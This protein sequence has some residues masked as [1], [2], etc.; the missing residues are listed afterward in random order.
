MK[1]IILKDGEEVG[2]G[3]WCESCNR[4]HGVYYLC[5]YYPKD[6]RDQIKKK[7]DQFKEN[8]KNKEWCKKQIDSGIPSE[9]IEIFKM[10]AGV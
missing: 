10:F 5:E 2:H 9:G 3:R 7:S 4:E 8:L 1:K 6:V